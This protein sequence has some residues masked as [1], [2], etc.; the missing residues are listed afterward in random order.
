L[1]LET[2]AGQ[3]VESLS[4]EE[5]AKAITG[6]GESPELIAMVEAGKQSYE[7]FLACAARVNRVGGTLILSG[8]IEQSERWYPDLYEAY[9][10][11][12]PAGGVSFKLPTW[13]NTVRYPGG[14]EDPKIKQLESLYPP[15]LFQERFGGEPCKPANLVLPEFTFATHVRPAPYWLGDSAWKDLPVEVWV[16]PGYAGAYAVLAVQIK[17]DTV[18]VVD[19]VYVRQGFASDVILACKARP[20]WPQVKGGVIDIAARQHQGMKSHVEVW[21]DEAGV[22]LNS[23]R[24]LVDDGIQRHRTFLRNP[25]TGEVRLWHDV[26]VKNSC[27]EYG[28]YKRNPDTGAV[29]DRDNHAMKAISYGLVWHFG[30]GDVM[31]EP[32]PEKPLPDQFAHLYRPRGRL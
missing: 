20:W 30:L 24:V 23:V 26:R 25:L 7:A 2:I 32:L 9:Q 17:G 6:T 19:E 15:D 29:I 22:M 11:E 14:R 27:A 13:C 3:V 8:T 16:D 10:A 28:L 12:N 18:W 31:V 1:R 21:R 5:G 4:S